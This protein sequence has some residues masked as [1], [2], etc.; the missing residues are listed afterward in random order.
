MT[1]PKLDTKFAGEAALRAYD[2][3]QLGFQ[4][5]ERTKLGC[6]Y[7]YPDGGVCSIGAGLKEL[8][9]KIPGELL[10]AG[11]KI[12]WDENIVDLTDS[13]QA[14]FLSLLQRDHDLIVRLPERCPEEQKKD[15]ID[16]FLDRARDYANGNM[17]P[18]STESKE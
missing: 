2:A 9:I 16:K 7:R 12:L 3:G 14:F 11:V 5:P 8:E 17:M 4:N 1:T 13:I 18:N 6:L 10:C 15:L